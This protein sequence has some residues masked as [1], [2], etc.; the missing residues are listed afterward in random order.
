MP[1]I[2]FGHFAPNVVIH[3][4]IILYILSVILG[5]FE[6]LPIYESSKL[7]YSKRTIT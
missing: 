2:A 7:V 5:D 3:V 6:N 1:V 4:C